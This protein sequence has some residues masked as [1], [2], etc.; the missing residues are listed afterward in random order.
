MQKGRG[1]GRPMGCG[2][3]IANLLGCAGLGFGGFGQLI[4]LLLQ[5]SSPA[6]LVKAVHHSRHTHPRS[7][8]FVRGKSEAV[9]LDLFVCMRRSRERNA[10]MFS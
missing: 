1:G 2:G 10:M 3:F 4:P 6:P 7:I 9:N 8:W 5:S